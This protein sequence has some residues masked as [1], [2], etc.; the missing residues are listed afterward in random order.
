MMPWPLFL[1]FGEASYRLKLAIQNNESTDP[2]RAEIEKVLDEWRLGE[3]VGD[4]ERPMYQEDPPQWPDR[5][6]IP[7][8]RRW[9]AKIRCWIRKVKAW[10]T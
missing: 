6:S 7:W 4:H 8:W 3:S 5:A 9:A 1:R 2:F 10:K